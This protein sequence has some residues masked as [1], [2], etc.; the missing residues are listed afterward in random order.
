MRFRLRAHKRDCSNQHKCGCQIIF[1]SQDLITSLCLN[2]FLFPCLKLLHHDTLTQFPSVV[3]NSIS[4]V[5]RGIF[6]SKKFFKIFAEEL[7][8]HLKFMFSSSDI[9]VVR[10][11]KVYT[12]QQS[13]R[14]ETDP[15]TET[16]PDPAVFP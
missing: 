8:D 2:F 12:M 14:L 11:K 5:S 6:T 3:Q 4:S 1:R 16:D 9:L 13:K 7:F 15:M 10:I